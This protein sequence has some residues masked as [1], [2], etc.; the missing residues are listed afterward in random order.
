MASTIDT[1][2]GRGSAVLVASHDPVALTWSVDAHLRLDGG[3]VR[4]PVS[5][6]EALPA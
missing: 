5:P 6:T 4:A 3:V 2:A 1:L